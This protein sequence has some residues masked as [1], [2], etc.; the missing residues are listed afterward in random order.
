MFMKKFNSIILCCLFYFS[1]SFATFEDHI[2]E[3]GID[4]VHFNGMSGKFYF[5]EM[6]GAGV[7]LFDYDNDGDLDI[8]FGQ[9]NPIGDLPKNKYTFTTEYQPPIGDRLYR[10]DSSHGKIK[11]TDVTKQSK[12][13]AFGYSMGIST[14]DID[15][16][17]DVD[18]YLSNYG[19]NQLWLNNG[20]GTFTD[21]TTSSQTDESGWSITASFFDYDKDGYLDLYV[22]NYVDYNINTPIKCKSYDGALDYCS[23]Q[24]FTASS[25][26]LYHNNG[27]GTFTN[28][29]AK[30]GIKDTNQPGLGVVSAD[31]NT[32]GWMDLYVANDGKPNILWLNNKNG[33]FTNKA[34]ES[35][36]AVNMTGV[37]E[38]SMGVDAA[39]YDNDG[40]IDLFM[41]HLNR[42]TNTLYVNNGKGWF[43]DAGVRM[44]IA[45]SSFKS[46]GFGTKWFDYNNDGYLDLFS[47]NG[48]VIKE[49][50]QVLL[51]SKLPLKQVNQLWENLGNNRYK[52]VSKLQ[53]PSFL[54]P[55]VS[56]GAAFGDIDND[57]DIDIVV[58]NNSD[59]PMILMNQNKTTNNWIGF[60]LLRTDINREDTGAVIIVSLSNKKIYRQLKT[61]GSY[62]SAH[63]SRIVIGIGKTS[64][65]DSVKI[66]WSDGTQQILNTYKIN[67][68]QTINREK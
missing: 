64:N 63:D 54:R 3:S 53:S 20:N 37:A 28:V 43:S 51:K 38:A 16:D 15:N 23:P 14:G 17:G 42:Q 21:I 7:A 29:S 46:T 66:V 60:K 65:I 35:G 45:S 44:G 10:N 68:Y 32:D 12:I 26:S 8:Y 6:M 11:F 24:A 25:D 59:R 61:D 34:L 40:D 41:T 2:N 1:C 58:S 13:K 48:A 27:N 9:G 30:S 4:F 19:H 39:D 31:F 52:E 62:A 50:K 67:S 55:S 57:G 49:P 18:L 5:H 22:V 47:A 56:R 36:V 33:S